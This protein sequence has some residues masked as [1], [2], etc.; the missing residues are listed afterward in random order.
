M[1]SSNNFLYLA[2]WKTLSALFK[3]LEIICL[4]KIRF[5]VV[6]VYASR[7][8]PLII[9][10]E[11]ARI[12]RAS[13][14]HSHNIK[15]IDLLLLYYRY[16]SLELDTTPVINFWRTKNIIFP[17][18]LLPKKN[19]PEWFSTY[20]PGL[21]FRKDAT[22]DTELG[23]KFTDHA[24]HPKLLR[25]KSS[26]TKKILGNYGLSPGDKFVCLLV[27]DYK[28]LSQTFPSLDWSAHDYR[29]HDVQR[30]V[31]AVNYL[32]ELGYKVFR[33]GKK[34]ENK[35]EYRHEFFFDYAF[36]ESQSL[37]ADFALWTNCSFAIS[38]SSG[39]D[40]LASLNRRPLGIIDAVPVNHAHY[41]ST[42]VLNY[43][44]HFFN[45]E[46]YLSKNEIIAMGLG[47]SYYS[48]EFTDKKVALELST[49]LEILNYVKTFELNIKNKNYLI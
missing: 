20:F 2:C 1:V 30:F 6:V 13:L 25:Y 18:F 45:N 42:T 29:N 17:H 32:T 5:R 14:K 15:I 39:I 28:Y 46:K 7:I 26:D 41:S 22:D 43:R 34:V 36:D 23:A 11:L 21:V 37:L 8:G 3:F 9:M 48:K 16:T 47:G 33:M 40:A 4:R 35:L 38:T 12:N 24:P 49:S 19:G 27:R 31:L 10:P 44:K